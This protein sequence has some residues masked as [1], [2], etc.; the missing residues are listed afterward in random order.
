MLWIRSAT[1]TRAPDTLAR[2][3]A[4]ASKSL[5]KPEAFSAVNQIIA[6]LA[7]KSGQPN[8]SSDDSS[9][10]GQISGE[11]TLATLRSYS[12]GRALVA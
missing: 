11:S 8:E 1:G 3:I 4:R 5:V 12:E 7:G 2:A 6:T 10:G 9:Q